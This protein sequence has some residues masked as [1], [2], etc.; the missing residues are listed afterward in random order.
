MFGLVT[1]S[2]MAS[3]SVLS[4][5]CPLTYGFTQAGGVSRTARCG[6]GLER[7]ER[8]RLMDSG[9]KQD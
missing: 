5:F 9:I 3:A 8:A 4:F 6:Q 2:Q 7:D 1:A